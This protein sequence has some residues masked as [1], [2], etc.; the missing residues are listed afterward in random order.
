MLT[1]GVELSDM[2]ADVK[3]MIY[4]QEGFHPDQQCLIFGGRELGNGCTISDFNIQ[5]E[6]TLYMKT[7]SR[8]DMQIFVRTLTGKTTTLQVEPSDTIADVKAKIQDKDGIPPDQQ[9]LIFA[10]KQLEDNWD[11]ADYDI[12]DDSILHNIL[13]L[14]GGMQIFVKFLTGKTITLEVEP[15]DTIENC[16]LKI[17]DKEGISPDQQR[18]I[19]AGE[20]LNDHRT[21]SDYNIQKEDTLHLVKRLLGASMQIFVKIYTGATTLEVEPYYTIDK[22]KAEIQDKEGIP[23]DQQRLTFAGIQLED[24]CS[25]SDYNIQNKYAL[26]LDSRLVGKWRNQK[27]WKSQK[28]TKESSTVFVE[29][30]TGET[31]TLDYPTEGWSNTLIDDFKSRC[32]RYE[33][34]I[35]EDQQC[36]VF[37][38]KRLENGR[39]FADYGIQNE[40]FLEVQ[41]KTGIL[42]HVTIEDCTTVIMPVELNDTILDV[43]SKI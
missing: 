20:Q 37:S 22:V 31:R 25:L 40:S 5:K 1:L 3:E 14:R 4:Y 18:L 36:L 21:L 11:L 13:R 30:L 17:Q 16:K 41:L 33:S 28:E 2:V 42:I 6:S 32:L 43:K 15:S 34:R 39:T 26:H 23:P 19:F 24:S 10:G 9:R 7:I 35:P 29:T 8:E 12:M 27:E 38:D